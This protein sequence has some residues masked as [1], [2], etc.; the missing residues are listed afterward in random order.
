MLNHVVFLPRYLV[1]H[2]ERRGH[3]FRSCKRKWF[4][5]FTCFVFPVLKTNIKSS[6]PTRVLLLLLC[7]NLSPGCTSNGAKERMGLW[8][9]IFIRVYPVLIRAIIRTTKLR[10]RILQALCSSQTVV[11][12]NSQAVGKYSSTYRKTS[13]MLGHCYIWE[14][15]YLGI[16]IFGR[17][18]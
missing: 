15:L 14:L 5:N 7:L 8:K 11:V 9:I 17:N 12:W 18:I 1:L 6:F 2:L 16:A 10:I 4:S 13:S 3:I